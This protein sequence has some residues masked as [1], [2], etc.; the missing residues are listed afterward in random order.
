M[1]QIYAVLTADVENEIHVLPNFTKK[2]LLILIG[3]QNYWIINLTNEI[4][5][6]NERATEQNIIE[7][8]TARN[9]NRKK[10]HMK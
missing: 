4:K 3:N 10:I 1:Q 6:N 8:Y 9:E 5:D 2:R 7:E